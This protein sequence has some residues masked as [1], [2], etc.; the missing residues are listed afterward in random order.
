M[1]RISFCAGIGESY[2]NSE[3]LQLRLNLA[4]G[5][6]ELARYLNDAS[7]AAR[8]MAEMLE[9]T[10]GECK[11]RRVRSTLRDDAIDDL[12]KREGYTW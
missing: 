11:Q 8:Q 12:L 3:E 2:M 1:L 4:D 7:H 6:Y 9:L 10:D 5:M